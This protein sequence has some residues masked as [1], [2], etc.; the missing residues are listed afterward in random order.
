MPAVRKR[1]KERVL[2]TILVVDDEAPLRRVLRRFLESDGHN[3][4]EASNGVEALDVL[5][6]K[7]VGLACVDLGMP[8]MDGFELLRRMKDEHPDTRAVVIS[9]EASVLDFAD[10][11]VNVITTIEKPFSRD[12]VLAGIEKALA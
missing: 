12:D 8:V 1:T 10:R 5:G 11:E 3:V 9:T 2:A 7:S 6:E 4:L